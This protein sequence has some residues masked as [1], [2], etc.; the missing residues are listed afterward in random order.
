MRVHHAIVFAMLSSLGMAAATADTLQM[1]DAEIRAAM[2][3]EHVVLE[4]PVKGMSMGQV[5]R[6]F[7]QPAEKLPAVGEPP[8]SRW[9]YGNY[10][11][12]F[13]HQFVLHSVLNRK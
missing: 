8:I 1:T 6:T 5:E 2:E 9:V 11:V 7:G 4:L 10:T 12:Y 3:K 13:E